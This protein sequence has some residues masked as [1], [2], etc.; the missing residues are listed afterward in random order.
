MKTRLSTLFYDPA[1]ESRQLAKLA[2]GYV[3]IPPVDVIDFANEQGGD[4]S[5][6]LGFP[7]LPGMDEIRVERAELKLRAGTKDLDVRFTPIQPSDGKGIFL[8]LVKSARLRKVDISYTLPQGF[9]GSP[10]IVVRTATP[11]GSSFAAGPPIFANPPFSAPGPMYGQVLAGMAVQDFGSRKV[12][13]FPSVLGSAWMIQIGTGDSIDKLAP[14]AVMPSISSVTISALP[15]N[16]MVFLIGDGADVTLWSHPGLLLPDVGYQNVSFSPLAQKYLAKALKDSGTRQG[17][18]TLPVPLKFHSDSGCTVEVS[19]KTL[20]GLYV[21]KPLDPDP[22]TVPLRGGWEDLRLQA[23]A[24]LQIESSSLR[25]TAKLL[26]RDLNGGSPEPLFDDPS[27]GMRVNQDLSAAMARPF[28]PLPG[29]PAGTVLPLISVQLYL[30][31]LEAAEAVVELHNDAA[32]APGMTV[33]KPLVRQLVKGFS[34][35]VEFELQKPLPVSAGQAPLWIVLRSNKGEVLWFTVP[36]DSSFPGTRVSTDHGKTWGIPDPMLTALGD[37]LALLFHAVPEPL[38]A[39]VV[40]VRDSR[41]I[42]S[43]NLL[44]TPVAKSPR[45]YVSDGISLPAPVVSRL[46]SATGQGRVTTQ[47]KVFSRSALD[48]TLETMKLFYDP[49][50]AR[51]GGE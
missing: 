26:G 23:P 37:P 8:S 3:A 14:A 29:S 4:A 6:E 49:F 1:I 28:L 46:V 38:P 32:S 11:Q 36:V 47:M 9:T 19:S 43:S 5:R 7:L 24:G 13:T 33:G 22:L 16:L 39:P 12:L 40:R 10:R 48:L 35:W 2:L 18:V 34:G 30:G 15:T 25:V 27:S 31:A 51:P 41:G 44:T 17:R 42:L 45:Q 21:V 50:Q 20:E